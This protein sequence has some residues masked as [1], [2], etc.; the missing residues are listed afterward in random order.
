M[1]SLLKVQLLLQQVQEKLSVMELPG[2]EA[3]DLFNILDEESKGEIDIE[4]DAD[5]RTE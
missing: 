4:V 1:H 3:A 5:C 2:E